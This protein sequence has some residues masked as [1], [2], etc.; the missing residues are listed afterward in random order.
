MSSASNN[1]EGD[2]TLMIALICVFR[3]PGVPHGFY[4]MFPEIEAA[5]K[6][7]RDARDGLRWLL[8]FTNKS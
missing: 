4:Y 7:D 1:T 5:K 6:V 2:F 3:Y 8:S